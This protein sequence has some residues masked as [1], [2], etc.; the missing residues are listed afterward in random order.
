VL[1]FVLCG[2][3]VDFPHENPYP[4]QKAL[5]AS[6]I[7]AY[8]NFESALLE[9]PTGTGKSLALLAGALSYQKHISSHI[10]HPERMDLDFGHRHFLTAPVFISAS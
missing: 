10:P 6:S 9:S 7:H 1:S 5:I 2:V 3:N 4:G 8:L